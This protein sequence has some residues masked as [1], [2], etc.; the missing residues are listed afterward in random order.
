MET[1]KP[2]RSTI[3]AKL[4]DRLR[5]R[6][7]GGAVVLT[8]GVHAL[9]GKTIARIMAAVQEFSEFTPDND[10]HGEH[11]FGVVA[12]EHV[13]F[14]KIDYYDPTLTLASED[15]T[16]EEKTCRVLTI[17]LREEH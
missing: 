3:I 6:G 10:P 11:D 5:Q 2:D 9:G 1:D 4:N 17:M 7:Q 15:P 16:S 8:S 12:I 14:W 13:V